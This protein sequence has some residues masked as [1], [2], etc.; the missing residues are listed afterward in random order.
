MLSCVSLCVDLK[1]EILEAQRAVVSD[2]TFQDKMTVGTDLQLETKIDGLLYFMNRIWVPS[3]GN[4]RALIM[5]ENH[6]S[7]YSIHPGSDKMYINLRHHY[8]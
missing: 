4:I 6:K 2:G 5:D 3:R 8:W 7:R 1:S